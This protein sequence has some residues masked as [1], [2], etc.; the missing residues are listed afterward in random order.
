[1]NATS[2]MG[3]SL[4]SALIAVGGVV[5]RGS[6]SGSSGSDDRSSGSRCGG[7]SSVVVRVECDNASSTKGSGSTSGRNTGSRSNNARG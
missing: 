6:R 7:G 5:V 1:V 4:L 2:S 3:T